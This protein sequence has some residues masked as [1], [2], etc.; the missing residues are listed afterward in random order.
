MQIL[1]WLSPADCRGVAKALLGALAI[2]AMSVPAENSLTPPAIAVDGGRIAAAPADS[3]GVRVFKGIPY[4]APPTGDRRWRAPAP[5]EPWLDVRA[6]DQFGPACT[7]VDMFAGAGM[8]GGGQG[9]DCLY[10]N[11]WTAARPGGEPLPVFVW[12]HGGAYVVGSGSDSKIDGASLAAQGVIV[13]TFN[14]RIGVFGFLAHPELSGEVP[15]RASGNYGLMDQL[16]ALRWVQHNI[17]RFG[18]DPSRVAIGGNSAGATSVNALMASPLG[19]GL[20]SRAIAQGGSAMSVSAPNDGSPLPRQVEEQKGMEFARSVGA[21]N[22]R[23]LR[24]LPADA[25]LKASGTDWSQWAWNASIDGYVVPAPPLEIFQQRR[26]ND[27]P[28][29]VG[30]AANEGANI[31]RAT[32]GGDDEPFAPQIEARFGK[33]APEVLRLYPA[34]TVEHERASKAA[35]AGEGFIS[36]PTWAWAVAQSRAGTE[37]VFTYKFAHAPPVPADYGRTSM[38]G[39]PGAFHGSEMSY[40]FGNFPANQKWNI[41][42]ADRE[43]SRGMQAYWLRFIATGDPNGGADLP[44][45]PAYRDSSPQRLLVDAK[46]FQVLPDA[47]RERFEALGRLA[48]AVPGSLS[49]R[50]MDARRWDMPNIRIEWQTK[51]KMRDGVVLTANIYHPGDGSEKRASIL[52]MTPYTADRYHN[53]AMYFAKHGYT[54]AVVDARGR[55]NSGGEYW[56]Y[57]KDGDDGHDVV[58]WLASQPWSNGKVGMW[59]GSA[60][61][62]NQWATLKEFPKGLASIVPIASAHPGFEMPPAF[63]HI[64]SAWTLNWL[65]SVAGHTLNS[66]FEGDTEYWTQAFRS[67]YLAQLPFDRLDEHAGMPSPAFDRWLS[68]PSMDEYWDGFLPSAEAYRRMNIPVLTITGHHDGVQRGALEF[69]RLHMRYGSEQGRAQHYLIIG[70]WNHSGTRKPALN[71]GGVQFGEQSLVDIDALHLQWYDWTLR[72]GPRPEFLKDR[73]NYYVE[74]VDEWRSAATLEAIPATRSRLFLALEGALQKEPGRDSTA[75]YLY[76][77][78]DT[79]AGAAEPA[80]EENYLLD[81]S[82]ALNLFGAGLVYETEPLPED[83]TISG[84]PR[85]ELWFAIDAPDTDIE[86]QLYQITSDGVS[87]RLAQDQLRVRYRDS[88]RTPTPAPLNQVVRGVFPDFQFFARRIAR[89]SKLRLVVRAPNSIYTQ[90]NYNS[91]GNVSRESAADARAVRVVLQ[92]GGRHASFLEL[93]LAT[94]GK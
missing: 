70:P 51:I 23:E 28:M 81:A 47:D 24:A 94:G 67:H 33:L 15:Q 39:P 55:G 68:H 35:I 56:P 62:Y 42:A 29:L 93:P 4:A 41:T 75:S 36:Y 90:K 61:G 9:E 53:Q 16:A 91:G 45:W 2:V 10:L 82:P 86:L 65:S 20:F 48:A 32:F 72:G 78:S 80:Y 25:L 12:I 60:A 22:I 34:D 58:E 52:T 85:A 73:V 69:H 3:H 87:I 74:E 79:R 26:Q 8:S 13:V 66:Q 30:W 83:V 54:F 63:K 49:Y 64:Y 57:E 6:S 17:A 88:S 77:P 19:K 1:P 71:V 43:I 27:V 59:G 92:Q 40:V 89:G 5:V 31:G 76:D 21:R 14:Y 38:I 50:G 7:Q 46:G 37:P 84:R 18:G 44:T 11:V